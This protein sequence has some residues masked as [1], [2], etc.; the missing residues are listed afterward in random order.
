MANSR[1]RTRK[2]SRSCPVGQI[3]RKAYRRKS[4]SRVKSRCIRDLGRPGRGPKT[5]PSIGKPGFLS[6][7]GYALTKS[8]PSRQL[9]LREASKK[10]K[11]RDR[12]S[13]NC[14]W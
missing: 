2:R 5:L 9:A 12:Q 3:R 13:I 8:V 6:S 14:T 1:K 4:G 10:G 11:P 7:H